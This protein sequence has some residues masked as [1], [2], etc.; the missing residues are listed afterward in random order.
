MQFDNS[1]VTHLRESHNIKTSNYTFAHLTCGQN[2]C[3][4]TFQSISALRSHFKVCLLLKQLNGINENNFELFSSN[5]LQ[6]PVGNQSP[7]S[8]LEST[9]KFSGP[10]PHSGPSS[11]LLSIGKIML[12]LR[13][14]H[15]VSHAAIDFLTK[16]LQGVF[17][18]YDF[19]EEEENDITPESAFSLLD[20]K[21]K[22]NMFFKND[23][24]FSSPVEKVFGRKQVQI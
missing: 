15:N 4:A 20:S 13:A 3:T 2:G 21:F 14:K 12:E 23:F 24:G 16:G 7:S 6:H 17:Q 18:N 5:D 22:R 10:V 1:G 8:N 19:Y 11:M 9:P